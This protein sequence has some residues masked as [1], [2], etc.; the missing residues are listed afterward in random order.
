MTRADDPRGSFQAVAVELVGPDSNTVNA[1]HA[2]KSSIEQPS[3]SGAPLLARVADGDYDPVEEALGPKAVHSFSA[4]FAEVLVD[5][6]L[7]LVRLNRFI[8]AYDAGRIINPKTARSQAIGGII[9]GVGQALLEQS[10]TDPTTAQ[11]INRNYSGYLVPTNADIPQLDILFAGEFDEEASPLGT[12]VSRPT[13][14]RRRGCSSRGSP[15]PLVGIRLLA[16]AHAGPAR[17]PGS[18]ASAGNSRSV[19]RPREPDP[20]PPSHDHHCL[21]LG[22]P[23]VRYRPA[24]RRGRRRRPGR[25]PR[26]QREGPGRAGPSVGGRGVPA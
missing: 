8:G 6:D 1:S 20:H 16:D 5:P 9:W 17:R 2:S 4:V 25:D 23:G 12:K 14:G 7:G 22:D 26:V 21:G 18:C 11:F 13:V 3:T 15:C 10:E 24:G 19:M